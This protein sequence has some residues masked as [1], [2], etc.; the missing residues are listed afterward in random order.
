M[1][2]EQYLKIER[3]AEYKSEYFKGEMFAMSGGTLNRSMIAG[4]IFA[5]LHGQLR[6]R[7]LCNC[8]RRPSS[9]SQPR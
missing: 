6:G 7:L 2:P 5:L 4:D 3:A 1:T 8:R 9:S